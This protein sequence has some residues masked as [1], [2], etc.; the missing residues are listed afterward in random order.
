[1]IWQ[2]L[3]KSICISLA[4]LFLHF[5]LLDAVFILMATDIITVLIGHKLGW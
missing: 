2:A 5:S 4:G 3:A 1:M